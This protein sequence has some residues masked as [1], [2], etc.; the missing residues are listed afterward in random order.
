MTDFE[1]TTDFETLANAKVMT[2][3]EADIIEYLSKIND[4]L[5]LI[6]ASFLALSGT[7]ISINENKTAENE[8]LK[9]QNKL[10]KDI[11]I[12]LNKIAYTGGN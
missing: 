10:L 2:G 7:M 9:Q 11:T 12:Y 5:A 3:A 4:N 6:N 1:I 8:L